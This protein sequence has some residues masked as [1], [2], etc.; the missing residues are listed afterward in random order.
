[1]VGMPTKHGHQVVLDG[2]RIAKGVRHAKLHSRRSRRQKPKG[3]GPIMFSVIFREQTV[4]RGYYSAMN[5]FVIETY[6]SHA[7]AIKGGV[8]I[9]PPK[10][11]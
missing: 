1:M 6:G 8:R 2:S 4:F 10:I 3:V 5:T 9:V 11:L 7:Q